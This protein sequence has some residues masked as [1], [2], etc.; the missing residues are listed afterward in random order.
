MARY[1]SP[2]WFDRIDAASQLPAPEAVPGA[3]AIE[4]TLTL[5]QVVT[6]GPAGDVEYQ[7]IVSGDRV[8]VAPG[9]AARADAVVTADHA[10][11]TAV[12]AGDLTIQEAFRQGRVKLKGDM[13]LLLAAQATLA[14][15]DPVVAGL[16]VAG[17]GG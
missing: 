1:L 4:G 15:L 12:H 10:T 2:E 16:R 11:A 6:G 3:D 9:R 8:R 14:A 13:A 7:V 5:Q 17:Q